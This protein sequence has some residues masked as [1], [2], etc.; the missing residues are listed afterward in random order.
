[1]RPIHDYDGNLIVI[2]P[3]L[4]VSKA[5]LIATCKRHK[6]PF[7]KDPTNDNPAF[8]RNRLRQARKA[9]ER[10]GLTAKRLAVT[11]MRLRRACDALDDY[12]D[13]VFH[14]AIRLDTLRKTA[15]DFSI[16][17]AAP[18]EVRLRILLRIMRGEEGYGPRLERLE[19]IATALFEDVNFKKATLGGF[20]IAIER[21]KGLIILQK[22]AK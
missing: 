4:G 22:E 3:L 6:I 13:L 19:S 12:A 2:R 21:K 14:Q 10:E 20:I 15:F 9:L 5:R 18:A 8:A 16:L 7:V 11:A 17:A 1:M